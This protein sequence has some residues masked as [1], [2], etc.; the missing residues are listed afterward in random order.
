LYMAWMNG[1][2]VPLLPSA[3]YSCFNVSVSGSPVGE[4]NWKLVGRNKM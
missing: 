3:A 2:L 4:S 1:A